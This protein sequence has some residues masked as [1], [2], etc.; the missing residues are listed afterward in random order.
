MLETN[1]PG[2]MEVYKTAIAQRP[3]PVLLSWDTEN[4]VLVRWLVSHN[5]TMYVVHGFNAIK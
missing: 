1:L 5:R 4:W 2:S 3:S